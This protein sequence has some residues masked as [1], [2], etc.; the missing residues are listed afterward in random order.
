MKRSKTALIAA[1]IATAGTGALAT[2]Q[3]VSLGLTGPGLNLTV[4]FVGQPEAEKKADK[5]HDE[6]ALKVIDAYIEKIGGKE[7]LENIESIHTVG[8]M[9]IPMAGMTGQ[10]ETF[11]SQPGK[12]AVIMELPGFGRIESGYDGQYGWSSDPMS[13]PRLMTEDEIADLK[14]QADPA[15]AANHRAKFSTIEHQGEVEF[16]GK[17]AVKIRLVREDGRESFEYYSTETGLMI[18]SEGIQASPMGELKVVSVLGDYKEFDG[19]RM[20]TKTTTSMGPQ[21]MVMTITKVEL[22]KVDPSAFTRPAAV[23][24]L[25]KATEED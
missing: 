2:A 5:K 7:M 13:G 4:S 11:I 8:I 20:A 16:D 3:T 17:K 6:K 14:T 25:V 12:I 21:Q 24:A 22:N 1:L 10:M 19:M 15:A 23:E 9:S 18:G